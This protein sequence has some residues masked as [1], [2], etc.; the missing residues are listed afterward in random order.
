MLM[1]IL[2]VAMGV[3]VGGY[4]TGSYGVNVDGYITGSYGVN[5]GGYITGSYGVNVDGYITGSYGNEQEQVLNSNIWLRFKWK[6]CNLVWNVSEYNGIESIV[7]PEDMIWIPDICLYDNS[8]YVLKGIKEYYRARV[9]HDGTVKYNFPSVLKSVCQID[10]KHFPFDQQVCNLTFGSWAYTDNEVMVMNN[11]TDGDKTSYVKSSEWQ[12]AELSINSY[13]R[14]Y[15]CCKYTFSEVVFTI[16]LSRKPAIQLLNLIYPCMII[17]GI[18]LIGFFLPPESGEKVSVSVTVLLSLAVFQL[19]ITENLPPN[20]DSLPY[21]GFFFIANMVFVGLCCSMSVIVM[22]IFYS[23]ERSKRL[24]SWI[25][26]LFL[27]CLAKLLCYPV[28]NKMVYTISQD[29]IAYTAE[30]TPSTENTCKELSLRCSKDFWSGNHVTERR[31]S[32]SHLKLINQ[33]RH[34]IRD[35]EETRNL[36]KEYEN[37]AFIINRI[38]TVFAIV[39]YIILSSVFNLIVYT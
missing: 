34:H 7:L 13:Q 23:G 36:C 29:N 2:L 35:R 14:L 26:F 3:N 10:I 19:V 31:Y 6:D 5:V 28:N 38:F 18:T 37:I 1:V 8:E 9:F 11:K 32:S 12:L 25:R 27:E 39:I 4:I 21:L 30:L 22:N 17:S 15:S 33:L 20:S 24:P 16:R